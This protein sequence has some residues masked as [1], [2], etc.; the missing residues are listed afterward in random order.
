MLFRGRRR[1]RKTYIKGS[2]SNL[3]DEKEAAPRS[4][5]PLR[6]VTRVRAHGEAQALGAGSKCVWVWLVRLRLRLRLR[7]DVVGVVV[8]QVEVG[9]HAR[10]WLLMRVLIRLLVVRLVMW[11][12]WAPVR[13]RRREG[14]RVVFTGAD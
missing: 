9:V 13:W 10:R 1:G 3:T 12:H 14:R 11:H 4:Q 2:V 6:Q 5:L 7:V 8:V